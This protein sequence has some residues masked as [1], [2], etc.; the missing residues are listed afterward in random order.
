M[1]NN[2]NTSWTSRPTRS[3]ELLPL[4]VV[5]ERGESRWATPE[6]P[7]A[8]K[9]RGGTTNRGAKGRPFAKIDAG[10]TLTLL[11]IAGSGIVTRI[12][13]TLSELDPVSLRSIRIDMYWDD[14]ELPAVSAPLGDFF[15]GIHG[16][17]RAL[18]NHFFANPEGKSFNCFIPM[19]YRR[20][21]RIILTN[22]SPSVVRLITYEVNLVSGVEHGDETL[23]FHAH[24]RR[25]RW[26]TLGRDFEILPRVH[27]RGRYLGA[28]IGII[29]KAGNMGWWGEGE[30]KVFVDGDDAYP[31]L[32]GTGTED[33][34]GTGWGLTGF[35][36]RYQGGHIDDAGRIA[37]YRYH[38]LDPVFFREDCRV[39]LQQLGNIYRDRLQDVPCEVKTKP[40]ALVSW[41]N[42]LRYAGLLERAPERTLNDP[43]LEEEGVIH[44]REDDVCALA[45]FYLDTSQNALPPLVDAD[46]RTTGLVAATTTDLQL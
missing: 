20:R 7:G 25:E 38:V 43:S 13:L 11:D 10:G 30:V 17:R 27:G 18:E 42:G 24:W 21:A 28:H 37:M 3:S 45:L 35:S 2:Q 14:A 34:I 32:V 16:D 41:K 15:C 6:N 9:G 36:L 1:G 39:T 22:E 44:Y 31:T 29:Q 5:P 26:T 8:E 4:Y 23:Y 33:Y 19:P 12:W 46:A 40:V